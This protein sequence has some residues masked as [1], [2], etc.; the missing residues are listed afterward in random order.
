M[1]KQDLVARMMEEVCL[2]VLSKGDNV[3]VSCPLAPY[4][5]RHKSVVDKRPSLGILVREDDQCVLNCFGCGFRCL[6]L[7]RLF[8]RLTEH[9]PEWAKFIDQAKELEAVDLD[10]VLGSVPA[11]GSTSVPDPYA[12]FP[13]SF[14]EPM[15]N[16]YHPYLQRRGIRLDTAKRWTSGFDRERK[17][18]VFPV[19]DMEGVL[20]GAVGRGLHPLAK[21]KYLNYWH[22]DK[23]RLVFGEHLV[24]KD[25]PVV[26]VVEGLLDAVYADQCLAD[27]LEE[28]HAVALLGA[29][30]TTQQADRVVKMAGEVVLA[31]DADGPGDRG[32]E[33]FRKMLGRRV[34]VRRVEWPA[35]DLDPVSYGEDFWRLVSDAPLWF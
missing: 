4:T 31:F 2:T 32:A 11:Y 1:L 7:H 29:Q 15:A 17:R 30:P 16:R 12:T 3:Q 19:R 21:P 13:E 34:P 18:V 28:H 9:D 25:E 10:A 8:E 33:Q 14:W 35:R 5:D 20:A 26:V 27:H 24:A 23:G 6:G 22:M